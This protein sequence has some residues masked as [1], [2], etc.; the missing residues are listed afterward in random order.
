MIF[1]LDIETPNARQCFLGLAARAG[2]LSY[3]CHKSP[4]ENN[5]FPLQSMSDLLQIDVA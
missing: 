1:L 4:R 3:N 5:R 2:A